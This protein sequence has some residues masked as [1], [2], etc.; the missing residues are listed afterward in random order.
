MV[1]W[2][3][4]NIT[5]GS[6]CTTGISSPK[7]VPT[8]N[9][10]YYNAPSTY[11]ATGSV[12]SYTWPLYFVT[13]TYT[14][15]D[16]KL[17][18]EAAI[19]SD[20]SIFKK[21]IFRTNGQTRIKDGTLYADVN[22]TGGN[23]KDTTCGYSAGYPQS[24]CNGTTLETT[25]LTPPEYDPP[26]GNPVT[27]T[28]YVPNSTQCGYVAPLTFNF[29]ISTDRKTLYSQAIPVAPNSEVTIILTTASPGKTSSISTILKAYGTNLTYPPVYNSTNW[30]I[31]KN[32]NQIEYNITLSASQPQQSLTIPISQLTGIKFLRI[33]GQYQQQTTE[34]LPATIFYPAQ[35]DI[36][37]ISSGS[38]TT[39]L[40]YSTPTTTLTDNG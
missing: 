31:I 2:I 28:T 6:W 39:Y 26:T 20:T 1:R 16:A 9:T 8:T 33:I 12:G 30:R 14:G 4:P 25:T 38:V 11:T 36:T 17:A 32:Q 15:T 3:Q 7:A 13:S 19:G 18:V 40:S 29:F 23:P 21:Y 35:I 37:N 34:S 24:R 10:N 5:I 27:T 22:I